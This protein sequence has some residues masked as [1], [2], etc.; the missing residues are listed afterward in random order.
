MDWIVPY[1]VHHYRTKFFCCLP[2][3]TEMR[4]KGEEIRAV[5]TWFKV[6]SIIL[7]IYV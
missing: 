3:R 2:Q 7:A 1:L 4:K 6:I 5:L